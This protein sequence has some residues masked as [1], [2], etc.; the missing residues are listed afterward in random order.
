MVQQ[1]SESTLEEA[2][3]LPRRPVLRPDQGKGDLE[4]LRARDVMSASLVVVHADDSL[5]MAW[6][7]MSATGVHHL[8]GPRGEPAPRDRQRAR[9]GGA[10]GH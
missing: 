5:L 9:A 7:T 6:E 1:Q 2:G 4:D 3:G 10:V 8:A